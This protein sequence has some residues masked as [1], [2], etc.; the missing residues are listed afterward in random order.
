MT[1]NSIV[2]S[3]GPEQGSPFDKIRHEDGYGREYWLGRE[4][5][6]LMEYS[7]WED[8]ATV[9]EKAKA[10]LALVQGEAAA[11]HHFREVPKT[12]QMPKGAQRQVPDARLTRFAAYLTAMAGD[13]TKSA[14][15]HARVYFAVR[16]RE[17][18][19]GALTVEEIRQT[20]LA[21][22]R[23]M[24]DYKIFRDMMVENASDYVPST[25]ASSMFFAMMQN[26]LYRHITGMS[27][28]EIKNAREICHWQDRE[29]GKTSPT[30]KDRDVAKNYLA[31]GELRKLERLL[32]GH[33]KD[34][35][36]EVGRRGRIGL[37][38]LRQFL[39][40]SVLALL[41]VGCGHLVDDVDGFR[42]DFRHVPCPFGVRWLERA[43][44]PR[45]HWSCALRSDRAPAGP[46]RPGVRR[47]SGRWW[48]RMPCA[49][50]SRDS[51]L[52]SRDRRRIRRRSP[53]PGSRGADA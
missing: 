44:S 23:E 29:N 35:L 46:P 30:K 20:A 28:V 12:I 3:R 2:P 53:W 31:V 39:D 32:S 36:S 45:C 19:L 51:G 1:E 50:C 6:P 27:A 38:Q 24:T 5:Q 14:V 8:F 13:D 18:E 41:T 49:G 26:R 11:Q 33:A 21:R 42:R 47:R 4:M 25:K 16:A 22:A 17:A 10:S 52:H 37:G 7:R 34:D 48:P 43:T 15:A 9:I 40:D